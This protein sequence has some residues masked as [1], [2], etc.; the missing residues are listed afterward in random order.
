VKKYKVFPA[1]SYE[2]LAAFYKALA[3]RCFILRCKA[4][5]C[6]AAFFTHLKL[7]IFTLDKT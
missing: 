5:W 2:L 6:G 3:G 4:A 1:S 7:L